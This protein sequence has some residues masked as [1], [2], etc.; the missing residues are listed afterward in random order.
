MFPKSFQLTGIDSISIL[1]LAI[2]AAY[3]IEAKDNGSII[4]CTS[5]SFTVSLASVALLGRGFNVWIINSGTGQITVDPSGSETIDGNVNGTGLRQN[6]G[7]HIFCDGVTLKILATK[8]SGAAGAGGGAHSV[9]LGAY[10]VAVNGNTVA[11]GSSSNAG[12][13]SAVSIG[14]SSGATGAQSVAIG[15]STTASGP[16]STAIGGNSSTQASQAITGNGAMALGGSYASG[17]NSFA[18]AV[19][20]NTSTY[21]AQ[22]ANAIV[23]GP[24]NKVT[25]GNG[26]VVGGSDS[27]AQTNLYAGVFNANTGT[28]SGGYSTVINGYGAFAT[29]N[30]QIAWGTGYNGGGWGTQASQMTLFAITTGTAVILTSNTSA[31]G[32]TNQFAVA[33]NQVKAFTGTIIGKQT[34]SA[35]IAAYTIT[36]TVVNNANTVTMPTGTLTAIGTPTAGWTAPTLTADNTNKGITITSGFNAATNIRWVCTLESSDLTYG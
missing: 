10:A 32:N 18:A 17:T 3:T 5:G 21:G 34:G 24:N 15:V 30:G 25:S 16:N 26:T 20:N 8:T 36:G 33:T 12:S 28:A 22:G 14:T 13:A 35:N 31:A 9:Q 27:L 6:A 4:D 23:M 19:A 7:A 1:R 11:I 2:S 29:Q